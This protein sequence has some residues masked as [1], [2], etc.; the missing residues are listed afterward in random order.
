VSGADFKRFEPGVDL[1][2]RPGEDSLVFAFS[3]DRLV[4]RE[5][6][7]LPSQDELSLLGAAADPIFLGR[8]G[9]VACFTLPLEP[10]L[11]PGPGLTA[12]GLRELFGKLD[13]EL[14]AVAGRA[15]Q[16]AEWFRNHAF[17]GRCGSPTMPLEEERARR[18]EGCGALYF[19]RINPAVIMLVESDLGGRRRMLLAQNRAFRGG[20]Y[21]VLAGFVEPG[22]SLEATVEREVREEVGIEV[23]EVR[24]FGSQPWPF[25]SQLMIGFVARHLS[26]EI[27]LD[28]HGEI[29]DAAWFAPD[30][31]L[32]PLPGRFSIARRLIDSFLGA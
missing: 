20:F 26:G 32:P 7:D 11:E 9:D 4:I 13:P 12:A 25:P 17:C 8:L 16:V 18:C 14:H 28:H 27:A 24:Y 30:D 23:G 10:G 6:H 1:H 5:G 31:A 2:R 3:G 15:F 22:E 19:P 29:V 21:S